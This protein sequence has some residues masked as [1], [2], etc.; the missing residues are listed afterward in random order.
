[1]GD[2]DLPLSWV[3]LR[4]PPQ[5]T[6]SSGEFWRRFAQESRCSECAVAKILRVFTWF[7]TTSAGRYLASCGWK[8][9]PSLQCRF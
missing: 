8:A 1:V 7:N 3:G 6:L 5:M 9:Y 4:G 2:F